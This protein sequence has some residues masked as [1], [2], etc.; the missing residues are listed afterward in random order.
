M[1]PPS[2][3]IAEDMMEE[4]T[5]VC[6]YGMYLMAAFPHMSEDQRLA[7]AIGSWQFKQTLKMQKEMF[8]LRIKLETGEDPDKFN[9]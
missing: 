1:T 3:K 5:Y 4:A 6:T 7:A 8:S 2:N 9:Q